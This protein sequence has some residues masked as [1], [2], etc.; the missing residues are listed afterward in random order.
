MGTER[1]A[2]CPWP[3]R[4]AAAGPP[5][6]GSAGRCGR[7]GWL[8]WE[9]HQ[10][11]GVR[12]RGGWT[13]G[14]RPEWYRL[15]IPASPGAPAVWGRTRSSGTAGKAHLGREE[16]VTG[17]PPHAASSALSPTGPVSI[18]QASSTTTQKT[19]RLSSDRGRGLS[20]AA[21]CA[22]SPPLMGS[23]KG[24]L[25]PL[26]EMPAL[27]LSQ[28]SSTCQGRPGWARVGPRQGR[29]GSSTDPWPRHRPERR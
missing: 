26:G 6:R 1:P 12:T 20:Q 7:E 17:R 2:R 23:S 9:G 3:P 25:P 13:Q 14:A 28:G 11:P 15:G 21:H 19:P 5:C 29:T 24:S 4:R 8:S 16:E 10:C 22:P 18:P 27:P